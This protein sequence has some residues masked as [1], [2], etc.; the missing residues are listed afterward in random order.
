M[1]IIRDLINLFRIEAG[2]IFASQ[3]TKPAL[4][5]GVPAL[6]Q[7]KTSTRGENETTPASARTPTGAYQHRVDQPCGWNV[8]VMSWNELTPET[9]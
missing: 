6:W 7:T 5:W 2:V 8:T 1:N 4:G 3:K 9:V